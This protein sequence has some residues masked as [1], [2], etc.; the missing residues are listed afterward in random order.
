[1]RRTAALTGLI[2]VAL[3]GS[4]QV[5]VPQM[6]AA[7]A[8]PAVVVS[9]IEANQQSLEWTWFLAGEVAWL[10]GLYFC[11]G[12]A[13][14]LWNASRYRAAT[15]LGLGGAVLTASLTISASIPWGM[16][17]YLGPQLTSGDLVLTLA[18]SRHFADAALSFSTATML[19]G[20]SIAAIGVPGDWFR[21]L[22]TG[23]LIATTFQLVHGGDHFITFGQTGILPRL[24]PEV[25]LAWILAASVLMLGT[26]MHEAEPA[27]QRNPVAEPTA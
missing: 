18:E 1:M 14:P 20:F 26:P 11:A 27:H 7:G 3:S 4:A 9:Y 17:I 16:L 15:L 24:A 22:A 10:F 8:P 25:A 6:P 23:G 5:A 2:F 19:L 21:A 12:L 13:V